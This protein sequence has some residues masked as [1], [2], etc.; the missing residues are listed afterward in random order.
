ML[1]F[2]A[3]AR[4]GGTGFHWHVTLSSKVRDNVLRWE[5]AHDTLAPWAR[6]TDP[7]GWRNALN[8]YGWGSGALMAGSQVY[9]DQGFTSYSDAV[10]AAVRQLILTRKPVGML[11]WGGSHAQMI[12]GYYGLV[13]NPL[14][15]NPDGSWAGGFTIAGLYLSDPLRG[16]R[17]V[18]RAVS[19]NTLRFTSDRRLRFWRY[20]ATDSPYDDPYTPGIRPSRSEWYGKFVLLLPVR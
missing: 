2:I 10:R 4:S 18:N 3:L 11:G 17:I 6:G 12:T 8:F 5:R 9:I 14:A 20:F 7:H 13:G 19:L 15:R 1:N 16:D